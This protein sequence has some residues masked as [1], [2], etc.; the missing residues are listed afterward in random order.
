MNILRCKVTKVRWKV[1]EAKVIVA[2]R[3]HLGERGGEGGGGAMKG[4]HLFA[5][6]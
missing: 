1:R 4:Q 6:A 2:G 3:G 5:A